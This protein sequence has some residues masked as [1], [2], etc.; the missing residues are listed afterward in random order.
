LLLDYAREW[1]CH[2]LTN[3]LLFL[4]KG[5]TLMPV[6]IIKSDARSREKPCIRCGYSLRK[7]TDSNHCPE[8]GLSVWLSL[9]QNDTLEMSN[10]DWLSRMAM[11]LWIMTAASLLATVA[12]APMSVQTFRMMQYRQ[13]WIEMRRLAA[14]YPDE[15]PRWSRMFSMRPPTADQTVLQAMLLAGAAGLIAYQIGL[16]VV[17]SNEGRYP[18][19]LAG[20]RLGARAL[21][22]AGTVVMLLMGLDIMRRQP[23]GFPEWLTRLTAVG[24][25]LLT[26][27]YLRQL[28]RRIPD[29]RL[30]R[31]CAWMTLAPLV[32]LFYS[33]I[34]DSN[35]LPDVVP[36]VY[37][38]VSAGL[39]IWFAVVLRRM[40]RLADKGWA[41]ET[42]MGR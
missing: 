10:P 29:K 31:F 12:L 2:W 21:C 25:G 14:Q 8:C 5:K 24:S 23:P 1:S 11:G 30:I 32:S 13:S 4:Q 27:G 20:F 28:A 18:D 7:I 34:R 35:W 26:W 39:F 38:P 16:L 36:L 9:N 37:L 41:A 6:T 17:T 33:F 42:A 19:R 40:A 22:V 3:R 15:P